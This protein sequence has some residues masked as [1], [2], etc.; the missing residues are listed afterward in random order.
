LPVPVVVRKSLICLAVAVVVDAIA[1]LQRTIV[2]DTVQ[3]FAIRFVRIAIIVV[4]FINAVGQ[5]VSVIVGEALVRGS[6][7]V[8]VNAV[9]GLELAKHIRAFR[10]THAVVEL[11]QALVP[12]VVET[13]ELFVAVEIAV[14]IE[15]DDEH[16]PGVQRFKASFVE[17]VVDA[18]LFVVLGAGDQAGIEVRAGTVSRWP[19]GIVLF[20]AL[21]VPIVPTILPLFIIFSEISA[22]PIVW[23]A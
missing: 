7:A 10:V 19:A 9:A 6:V 16:I 4:V 12:G 23:E 20:I 8:V 11:V 3:G 15:T 14:F 13:L 2:D 5:P 22:R 1:H 21:A 17:A 18:G